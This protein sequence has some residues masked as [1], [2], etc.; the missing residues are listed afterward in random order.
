MK[1]IVIA[2]KNE[3]KKRELKKLLDDLPVAVLCLSDIRRHLPNVI[4]DGKT[5]AQN[6]IKKALTYSQYVPGIIVADDSGITVDALDGRPGVRSARFAHPKATDE[7]NN[8]KLLKLMS[9]FPARKRR[10]AF[11]C[12]VAVA[13]NGTLMGTSEGRCK[14]T[15]ECVP[16]GRSGFGYDPLFVP[17]GYKRTFAELKPSF[18]NRI[19]HRGMALKKAKALLQKCLNPQK[20]L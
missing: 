5:F 14:G 15:I 18:K 19:S 12:V 20:A 3:K 11:V 10:A 13:E 6:A 8:R 1:R 16:R 9:R 4:E 2:T 17:D 7:D